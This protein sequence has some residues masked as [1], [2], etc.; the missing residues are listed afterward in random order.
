MPFLLLPETLLVGIG[1]FA[2][3]HFFYGTLISW[4]VYRSINLSISSIRV[5][6]NVQE[7]LH[8]EIF[9]SLFGISSA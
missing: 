1:A 6:F 7:T 8:Q 4:L 2:S 9:F 5:R 3:G